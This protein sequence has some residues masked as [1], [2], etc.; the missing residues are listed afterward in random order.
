MKEPEKFLPVH[1]NDE[2]KCFLF[3]AITWDH[4]WKI[5]MENN[6]EVLFN[7]FGK[8]KDALLCILS[9]EI[10]HVWISTRRMNLSMGV[11]KINSDIAIKNDVD[12][13]TVVARNHYN[14]VC[15][16]YFLEIRLISQLL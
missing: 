5:I 14:E 13:V 6:I 4:I 10:N 7:K 2:D 9:D 12:A 1:T 11:I 8:T 15:G 3:A 16:L